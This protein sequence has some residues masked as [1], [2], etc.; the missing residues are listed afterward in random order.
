MYKIEFLPLDKF[1]EIHK[2][3]ILMGDQKEETCG[4]YALTYILRGLGYRSHNG[5]DIDEDYL[6][7]LARTRISPE[8]E[9]LRKEVFTKILYG[10]MGPEEA[11]RRYWKIVRKYELPTTI[12]PAEL[13]TSAEGVKYALETVTNGE[14]A[15]VPIPSRRGNEV[16]FTED[17]FLNLINL[18]VE[19]INTW[20]YQAILNWQTGKLVNIVARFHDIF[21]V[22]FSKDPLMA[23]GLNPWRVG[24]FV[25][26][27]GFVKVYQN[28]ENRTYFLIRDS[29][30]NAGYMGYHVQPINRVREALVR[31]DGREGGILLIVRKEIAKEVENAI[32]D[33]GLTVGL[34]NNGTPF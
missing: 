3:Y 24:H 27:A 15:G 2:E 9:N 33:I 30:K 19:N 14:L 20:K 29:Y 26:L 7:Y 5:I 12:N 6:S 31:D 34:W 11:I 8:E 16:Y 10:E 1:I 25:S 4:L 18:L 28:N 13:G 22:L 23:I 17:K 32:K 21:L